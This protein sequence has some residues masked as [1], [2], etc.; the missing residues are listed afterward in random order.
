MIRPETKA[1][2]DKQLFRLP[3]QERKDRN[4]ERMRI[5]SRQKKE[6]PI[7]PVPDAKARIA[8]ALRQA[9]QTQRNIDA[10]NEGEDE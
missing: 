5:A 6:N 10:L 8:E 2:L 3:K 7:A 9:E 1:Y 4:A